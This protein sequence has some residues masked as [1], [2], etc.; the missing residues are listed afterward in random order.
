MPWIFDPS[1]ISIPAF[2]AAI[3]VDACNERITIRSDIGPGEPVSG[4]RHFRP[5][6]GAFAFPEMRVQRSRFRVVA[7]RVEALVETRT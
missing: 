1:S 5:G 7:L 3:G 6:R 2:Y 4:A